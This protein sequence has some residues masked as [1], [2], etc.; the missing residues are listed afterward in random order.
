M[1]SRESKDLVSI[2]A[3]SEM[4]EILVSQGKVH[5]PESW[6]LRNVILR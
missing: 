2:L 1:K 5:L 6:Q 3:E 4:L